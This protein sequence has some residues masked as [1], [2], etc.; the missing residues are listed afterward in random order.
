M[1][2][3]PNCVGHIDLGGPEKLSY[4]HWHGVAETAHK[5]GERQV[6]CGE[7]GLWI[8]GFE[9]RPTSAPIRGEP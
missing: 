4:L 5:R 8:F 7:C 9:R 1:K 2:A 6:Q 3:I